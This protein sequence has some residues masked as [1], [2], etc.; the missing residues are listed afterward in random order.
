M[1]ILVV[2]LGDTSLFRTVNSPNGRFSD[3]SI[4][5]RCDFPIFRR[6]VPLFL[7]RKWGAH[8]SENTARQSE[9]VVRTVRT[10]FTFA[11]LPPRS[12]SLSLSLSLPLFPF[13]SLF[14]LLTY[15][16]FSLP[17]L[18]LFRSLSFSFYLSLSLPPSLSFSLFSLSPIFYKHVIFICPGS[19]TTSVMFH[20]NNTSPG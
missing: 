1:L 11:C 13:L 6:N 19:G 12:V 14:S 3:V 15:P 10:W 18:V 2:A 8:Y 20:A 17:N 7:L 5:R 9:L 16:P 4:L